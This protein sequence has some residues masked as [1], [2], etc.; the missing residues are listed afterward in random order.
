[1]LLYDVLPGHDLGVAIIILTVL[2]K[3]ILFLPSLSSIK[4]QHQLQDIQPKVDAIR[5]KYTNKEEQGRKLMELYKENK[6]NPLSSCLPLLI[7]IPIIYA[8]FRVFSVITKVD[9][10]TGLLPPD[11]LQ[12]L[13]GYLQVKFTTFSVHTSMFG[14]IDLAA[15]KNYIMAILAGAASF[16]QVRMMQSKKP[17]IK[18]EG[19]KDESVA[20]MMNKQTTYILP[21]ITV[22]FGISFPTGITLYWLVSTLFTIAQQYYFIK[23]H[24]HPSAEV[25]PPAANTK[26]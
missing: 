4:S 13:Y 8:L 9:P 19:S 20:S 11:Q 14:F 18:S 22:F 2:I 24:K 1:M 10:G 16:Y 26:T 23:R 21:I 25:L 3:A 5:K 15:T 6:V 7:Q 12:H 17:A